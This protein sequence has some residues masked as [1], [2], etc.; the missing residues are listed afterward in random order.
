MSER[1]CPWWLGYLLASPVRRW[2]MGQDPGE[3]L[4]PYVCPGMTALEPGPGMG[5]FTLELARLVGDS[6]R[7]IAIDVQQKMLDGLRRR[8]AKA[9]L[10]IRI[11]ARLAGQ[12]SLDISDLANHVDF[13]LAFAMVHEMPKGNHFFAEA[14][15]A[16]KPA[17]MLLLAEPSGHVKGEA[18]EGELAEAQAAGLSVEKRPAIRHSHAALLH[19]G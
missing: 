15:Q 6:G 11:E 4:A 3:L 2:L 7:V 19:K 5:F 17:A 12:N 13:V 8:A 18:F 1:I 16:M 9:G 10:A 14:A